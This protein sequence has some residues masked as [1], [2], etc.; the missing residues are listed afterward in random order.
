MHLPQGEAAG[1]FRLFYSRG[2][3]QNDI[4]KSGPMAFLSLLEAFLGSNKL[5]KIVLK[6][7]EWVRKNQVF[8]LSLVIYVSIGHQAHP[9][10]H[11]YP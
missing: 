7:P 4:T 8:Q 5:S 11:P 2:W 10:A 6:V 3:A 9:H 1:A